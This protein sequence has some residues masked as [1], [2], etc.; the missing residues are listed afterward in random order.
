MSWGNKLLLVF[1]GFA[2]LMGTLVYK[3]TQQ[4]FE[5][6]S[7]DYYGDELRYQDNIDGSNNANKI[8]DLII[9]QT[10]DQLIVQLPKEQL[11][12]QVTG[13]LWFYCADNASNDR[14]FALEMNSDGA[15]T[16]DK[17]KLI[18]T[19]YQVKISWLAG[20][21]KFYKEVNVAVQ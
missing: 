13:K 1:I 11:G 2:L 8:S 18:R 10:A 19:N 9:A 7:N 21:Q 4:T 12:M 15:M 20:Q 14:K 3:C 6:V 5:L 17:S 16:I